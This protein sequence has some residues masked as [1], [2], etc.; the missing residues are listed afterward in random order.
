MLKKL[1]KS[2]LM[3]MLIF[4]TVF[5]VMGAS[6]HAEE[7]Y[8]DDFSA[9]PAAELRS[10]NW[11]I[12]SSNP[13]FFGGDATR[14]VRTSTDTGYAVYSLTG[15]QSF[16]LQAYYFSGSTAVIK[17]YGS[18]DATAWT[19]LPSINE[20]PTATGSGWYGTIYTPAVA[21]PN[22]INYLKIE[23]S[24]DLD[25]WLMQLGHLTLSNVSLAPQTINDELDDVSQ[26][27]AFSTNWSLDTSNPTFFGGDHSRAVRT[28]D[29]AES[30]VYHLHN[31][32]HF[33]V[34]LHSF[35]GSSGSIKFY[36]SADA[37][38]W[39][40][41]SAIH[42]APQSTGDA[43]WT[44]TNYTPAQGIPSGIHYLKI[45]LSGDSAPWQMQLGSVSLSNRLPGDGGNSGGDGDYY[46]DSFA[47]SDSNDGKTPETAWKTFSV[48]NETTFE[49][50]DR[51][52]LKKGGIWNEQLYPKGSGT[53]D[54]PITITSYGSGSKPTINGGGMA[55]AAVYLRNASNWVIRDLEVTNYASERG[56]VYREGIMV[57]N[58]NGGTLKNIRIQ[59]NYIHDVSSSFRYPTVSGAEGG[60]HAFGGISVYV[61][62]TTGTDKFDGVWIEGNTVERIGR[63]GIV[64]WDQR[65]NGAD[66]ATVNVTIRGNYVKQADSD[67]ILTFGADG[68]LIEHNIAE[69]G[70]NYSEEG[71]FNGS[72]AIWPTRGKNNIVQFNE[73]F[74]TNKPEG[75][76]Q[77]FNLDID[78]M[79]SVVQYNYS[80]GN[81]GGFM[82]FVDAR[83][84]PGVLTGSS[85]N[86]VRYNISQNDLT[87]TFN[88]AGGVTPDTQIYNNTIFIG[89]GQNTKIIDHEWDDAGN[90]NAPYTFRNNLVYNLGQGGYNLPGVNGSFD[91]NLMY[92]NHPVSE[93]ENTNPVT[94]NPL[95]VAQGSG[96]IGWNTVDGYKLR[97]GSPA[98][99]A[100]AIIADNGGRDYWGNSISA[101][102]PPN[103]GAY[104]GP[105]LDP[106]TLPE[107]P[108]DDLRLYFQGLKIAPHITDGRNGGISLQLQ[109]TN[110]SGVD[111]LRI[112]KISWK[113]GEGSDQLSG[114]QSQL[115]E[116]APNNKFTYPIPLPGFSESV[117]YPLELTV[118]LEGYETVHLKQNIDINRMKHQSDTGTPSLIDL[119]DG[120]P[121]LSGYNGADD[122]SGTAQLR[123][124]ADNIY[125]T[126]DIR[127]DVFSHNASGIN[128]WQNDSIQFS[129]APGVPGD[130]QSWYEYGISQTPEG[131]QIYRWL[132]MKGAA[133][134]VLTKG[135]LSVDRNEATKITSYAL[136]LPWSEVSPI[137]GKGGNVLSFSMLVN[138]NDGTGRKGYIEWGSGIG[139]AKDPALF[140]TFQFMN[141]EDEEET[142][143]SD[144]ADLSFLSMDGTDISGF[145]RNTLTYTINVPFS[146]T[147]VTVTGIPLD[148]KAKL[149]VTSGSELKVGENSVS[150]KVTAANGTTTKTYTLKVVRSEDRGGTE[151]PGSSSG[152]N[153]GGNNSNSGGKI[154]NPV[155]II[156]AGRIQIQASPDAE[157]IRLAQLPT[158]EIQ[159]AMK[160]VQDGAL[161][162]ELTKLDATAK[163]VT[164]QLP[165]TEL[166]D[167]VTS[168]TIKAGATTVTFPIDKRGSN[169]PEGSKQLELS[170]HFVDP[171]TLSVALKEKW[172]THA[173]YRISL[174]VDGKQIET[175][176]QSAA[177]KVS[178]G[179]KLNP[180][181]A[182]NQAIVYSI[183]REGLA[184]VVKNS[185]Y[186]SGTESITF[187]TRD[188]GLYATANGDIHFSDVNSDFAAILEAL[189]SRDLVHGTGDGKYEP[190]RQITRAEFVQLLVS[191][192][193]LQA[194]NSNTFEDVSPDAWYYQA[195]STA[196]ALKIVNGRSEGL[197][198]A[199]EPITRQEMAVILFRARSLAALQPDYSSKTVV[200]ADQKQIG[201]YA[202]EAVEYL[203][204]SGIINGYSD[205]TFR[206]LNLT[207]RAEAAA[208]I[209]R[210]MGL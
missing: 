19:E 79:D 98:L 104:N 39:T 111:P 26:L 96:G 9:L 122:L 188:F 164:F 118:D 90:I 49:A 52:L 7:T 11:L 61:G 115:A 155:N 167:N 30:L 123:W 47:G 33:I 34:R 124:D 116:I 38:T 174:M 187:T 35:A 179:Y 160:G 10:E 80:H 107:A 55:G 21:L 171:S 204:Q 110:S 170:I 157:G 208:L 161:V 133:T 3:I 178:F 4:T 12:D 91:H 100:G 108:V 22:D 144:N 53:D 28:A 173:V 112:N 1:A 37:S 81:K 105:G 195:V 147:A 192:L 184:E 139:A 210:I 44:G 149:T 146:K 20:S 15:I 60:P 129:F 185:K 27:Y 150:I 86:V 207:T 89:T 64:V 114:S 94:A 194:E 120:T 197:F 88:F 196:Q 176:S 73:S 70:G 136:A 198:G 102:N 65:F 205:G 134:G 77:G 199:K 156:S 103:I 95:L 31:L 82:L 113:I 152:N 200:F 58:A 154:A 17:F 51:I 6:A 172:K 131:P 16:T 93:P 162:L 125:L 193:Y 163:G 181:E 25:T 177:M 158:G 99:G 42:E 175:L 83:L 182:P 29:S 75:D 32:Q 169:I 78:T 5:P 14:L 159:K 56:T 191:A 46:V 128:I 50:G 71:E 84:T 151:T 24:G 165:V 189:A 142:Q 117:K 57:E 59:D 106:A 168:L 148:P 8:A 141:V 153:N 68:A 202:R 127:D 69:E 138:D 41:I 54:K 74:N 137:R 166:K 18:G 121:L 40:E 45:E 97:E 186:V 43:A 209:Y 13:Q 140:R 63:T 23:I 201:A 206:P 101:E 36:G 109:F 87:H 72:A 76:G 145:D 203:Q 92:G 66:Y 85:N 130:S 119:A 135:T 62:G 190:A 143:P 126:A 132:S 180:S 67:G 2:L 183:T 48:V